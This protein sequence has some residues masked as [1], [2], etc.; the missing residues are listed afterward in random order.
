MADLNSE[1]YIGNTVLRPNYNPSKGNTDEK[2][3][4]LERAKKEAIDKQK[5][6]R[7]KE[8]MS[9]LKLIALVF[10]LGIFIM[11]RYSAI[12]KMQANLTEAKKQTADLR[13][14]N[15]NL[16][17]TLAK[18]ENVSDVESYSINNLHMEK[19]IAVE[20]IKVDLKKDNFKPKKNNSS[21]LDF[22][23]KLRR[24]LF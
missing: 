1:R 7:I 8:K 19:P 15:D 13:A 6:Q 23:S 17:I 21:S 24:I 9:V 11:Y 2:Y 12:Y 3:K 20:A 18:N 10:I 4:K 14:Q 22:W 5:K 16:K